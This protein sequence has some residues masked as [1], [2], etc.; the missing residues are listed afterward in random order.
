MYELT[1]TG[2]SCKNCVKHVTEAITEADAAGVVDVDL[3]TGHVKVT[4]T[5]ALAE[6]AKLIEDAG[7]DVTAQRES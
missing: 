2:M 6:V 1:V 7:Y 5:L 4:S 3:A